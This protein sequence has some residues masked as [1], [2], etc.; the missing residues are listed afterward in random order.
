MQQLADKNDVIWRHKSS[1]KDRKR[2]H[3]KS[4]YAVIKN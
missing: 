1:W 4:D 2:Y 3:R